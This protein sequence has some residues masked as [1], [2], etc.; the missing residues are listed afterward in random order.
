MENDFLTTDTHVKA[1]RAE[2][3]AAV[4]AG[5]EE[6]LSGSGVGSF[7]AGGACGVGD[8]VVES[9]EDVAAE[10]EHVDGRTAGCG[11]HHAGCLDERAI[12]LGTIQ[13]LGRA[14]DQREAIVGGD[15]LQHQRGRILG[16]GDV[17]EAVP[18]DLVD[19]VAGPVG[20]LEAIRVNR[21]SCTQWANDR[22]SLRGVRARHV[23]RGR[24]SHAVM[25]G[26]DGVPRGI[27]HDKTAVVQAC[28]IRC[29]HVGPR[30][31]IAHVR[32]GVDARQIPGRKVGG[33]SDLDVDLIR[34]RINVLVG[35]EGIVCA[36]HLDECWVG[37]I[38]G[39]DGAT[40]PRINHAAG[41]FGCGDRRGVG[42]ACKSKMKRET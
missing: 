9:G 40:H 4:I 17:V 1:S 11:S 12:G 16:P 7:D 15:L 30:R 37:E 28:D 35:C 31:P 38:G 25:L 26:L 6:R 41:C 34:M 19:Q 39:H 20:I 32:Q 42:S 33:H 23:V 14:A 13:K 2:E 36:I 8:V 27:V 10:E 18:V 29:P 3:P 21:S 22:Q 24:H 5:F